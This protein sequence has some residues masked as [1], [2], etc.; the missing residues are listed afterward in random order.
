MSDRCPGTGR[1]VPSKCLL[2]LDSRKQGPRW[3]GA[4]P[5]GLMGTK[6]DSTLW[7]GQNSLSLLSLDLCRDGEHSKG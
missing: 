2:D 4:E 1:E 7:M 6:P 5:V 3:Q